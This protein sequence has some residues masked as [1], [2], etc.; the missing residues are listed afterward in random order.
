[1]SA[2]DS[3]LGV[4]TTRGSTTVPDGAAAMGATDGKTALRA[5]EAHALAILD[6][7]LD[8]VITID[9]LGCV[10]EFNRAAEK[11]FGYSRQ[12]VLG[13]ELAELIVPPDY[14]DAHRQALARWS[15]DG[16]LAG[17]GAGGL[18]GRRIDVEAMRSDGTVFPAE[19]AISRVDVPG[20]ARVHRVH[21]GHQRA[22]RQ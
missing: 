5:G 15:A 7:A 18:L 16:P 1:M 2:D 21:P 8:A 10:L 22:P 19:L 3:H 17:A 6:A 20:R 12:D 14:R 4:D 11:T 9:H 13:K